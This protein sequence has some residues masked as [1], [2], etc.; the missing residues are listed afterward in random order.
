VTSIRMTC[1]KS[2][3]TSLLNDSTRRPW[4]STLSLIP[5]RSKAGTAIAATPSTASRSRTS[6]SRRRDAS[7]SDIGEPTTLATSSAGDVTLTF[8][9]PS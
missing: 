6:R 2:S 5:V 7:A 4:Y 9:T 3:L 8:R 1:A